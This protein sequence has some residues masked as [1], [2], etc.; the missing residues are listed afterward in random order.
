MDY[1]LGWCVEGRILYLLPPAI[2]TIEFSVAVNDELWHYLEQGTP[3]VHVI[4]N[5]TE[6]KQYP[7]SVSALRNASKF[8]NHPSLGWVIVISTNPVMNFLSAVVSQM[9][10][11]SR[12]HAVKHVDDALKFLRER[13]TTIQW[14]QFDEK[15]IS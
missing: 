13:D 15:I 10:T 3:L 12:H 2:T 5:T 6:L 7:K 1:K 14:E 9:L 11:K 4:I 8:L